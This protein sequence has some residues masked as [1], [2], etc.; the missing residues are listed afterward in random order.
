MTLKTTNHPRCTWC[1]MVLN[2]VKLDDRTIAWCPNCNPLYPQRRSFTFTTPSYPLL[3]FSESQDETTSRRQLDGS[4]A[5]VIPS[6]R[7]EVISIPSHMETE[8]EPSGFFEEG[9]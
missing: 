6:A 8:R 4:A 9:D 5:D 1:G 7:S 3:F 2:I